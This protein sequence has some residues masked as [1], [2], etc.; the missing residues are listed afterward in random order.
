MINLA[1][2]IPNMITL[3]RVVLTCIVNVCIC[4]NFSCT[5]IP[6]IL[7][8]VIFA[9][10]FIDGKIARKYGWT[11]KSGAIFDV[12]SDLFYIISS[13]VVLYVFHILPLWF[14]FIILFKFLEF[15]IT[16]KLIKKYGSKDG[17]FVF[18]L[19]GRYVAVLFYIVPIL[20]YV[21]FQ[22]SQVMYSLIVNEFIFLITFFV[23][24]SSGH[25]I[26]NCVNA[27]KTPFTKSYVDSLGK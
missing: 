3:L 13:Y 27:M 1:K 22:Y 6:I 7:I 5:I 2:K 11:S 23:A 9:S 10:D 18:D 20:A 21:S 4:T 14:L 26:W 25:R 17:V 12:L 19:I 8:A 15:T 24:I 16:S